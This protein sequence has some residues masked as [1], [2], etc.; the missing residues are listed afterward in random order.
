[1]N[2]SDFSETQR[3]RRLIGAAS[4]VALLSVLTALVYWPKP[5]LE[6]VGE[7]ALSCLV[8]GEDECLAR[9]L[10]SEEADRLGLDKATLIRYQTQF[11]RPIFSELS[12]LPGRESRTNPYNGWVTVT[13]SYVDSHGK[14]HSLGVTVAHAAEG[15][16][17]TGLTFATFLWAAILSHGVNGE[18][19]PDR[20][21]AVIRTAREKGPM[22][23]ALGLKGVW[24]D[25]P[26]Q[27]L[28][29]EEL[30]LDNEERLRKTRAFLEAQRQQPSSSS[31]PVS[32]PPISSPAGR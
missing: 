11:L 21:A 17:V 16:R 15:P 23:E 31:P 5:S 10:F 7:A 27:V 13:K 12:P 19:V 25:S 28:T 18:V 6:E 9:F 1:M 32:V 2:K 20:L 29:W 26:D 30:A 8:D 14:T 3:R 22:L 24:R 4:S